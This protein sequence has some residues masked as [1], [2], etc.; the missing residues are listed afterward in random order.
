MIRA[1]T[2]LT[3]GAGLITGNAILAALGAIPVEKLL[4]CSFFQAIALFTVWLADKATRM[5]NT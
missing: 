5:V 3:T 2:L 4:D 1:R